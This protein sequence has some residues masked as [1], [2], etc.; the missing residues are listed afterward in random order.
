LNAD[1][2]WLINSRFFSSYFLKL[3]QSDNMKTILGNYISMPRG[4]SQMGL[5][6]GVAI[7]A[8]LP[9]I[10]F[11]FKLSVDAYICLLIKNR[12]REKIKL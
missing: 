11:S 5:G 6:Y 7:L 1:M 3:T 10:L 8:V 4:P 9:L 12:D 2:A